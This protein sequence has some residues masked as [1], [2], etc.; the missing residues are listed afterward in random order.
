MKITDNFDQYFRVGMIAEILGLK[1]HAVYKRIKNLELYPVA[2]NGSTKYYH[3]SAIEF[4]KNNEPNCKYLIF[5]S[6][7]NFN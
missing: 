1:V 3:H 7:M 2:M 4:I 6:K 5:E